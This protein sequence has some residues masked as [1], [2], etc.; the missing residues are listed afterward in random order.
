VREI[1]D[2]SPQDS[3]SAAAIPSQDGEDLRL[4]PGHSPFRESTK[5]LSGTLRTAAEEAAG[6]E[7]SVEFLGFLP[8][9]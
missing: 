3:A 8:S 9:H 6:K 2:Q 7:S 5:S 4:H 1:R